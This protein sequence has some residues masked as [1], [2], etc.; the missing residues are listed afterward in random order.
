MGFIS[1]YLAFVKCKWC[2]FC[3]CK[4]N[5]SEA[6]WN[7]AWYQGILMTISFGYFQIKKNNRFMGREVLNTSHFVSFS[8]SNLHYLY[9]SSVPHLKICSSGYSIANT[10]P[11]AMTHWLRAIRTLA[12]SLNLIHGVMLIC[13]QVLP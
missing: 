10:W 6:L 7:T 9:R 5:F 11:G 8:G 4:S 12:G 1:S 3:L 13:N 2:M